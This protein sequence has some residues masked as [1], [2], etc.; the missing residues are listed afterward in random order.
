MSDLKRRRT[1]AVQEATQSPTM[2]LP[3]RHLRWEAVDDSQARAN[4]RDGELNASMVCSFSPEGALTR[5]QSD[6]RMLRFTGEVPSRWVSA[7]WVME[8]GDYRQFGTLRLPTVMSV[9]WLLPEGEFEQVRAK[10]VAVDFD[11]AARYPAQ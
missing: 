9:R 10:T 7:R 11:V 3:G 8:R 5:C 4:V 6:D 1:P 2:L